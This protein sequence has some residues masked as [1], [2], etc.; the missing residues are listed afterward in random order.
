[1]A[2]A[3]SRRHSTACLACRGRVRRCTMSVTQRYYGGSWHVTYRLCE[4]HARV[5]RALL[6]RLATGAEA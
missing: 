1:M 5:V 4:R 6:A 2:V 3:T